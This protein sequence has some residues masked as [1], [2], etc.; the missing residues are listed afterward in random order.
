MAFEDAETLA[1]A[2]SSYYK[3]TKS[4]EQVVLAQV[5]SKWEQH[6]LPRVDKILEFTTQ[7]GT[8]RKES[9]YYQQ[10]VKEW[11]MWAFFKVRG[12]QG[13]GGWMYYYNAE[14]V[15]SDLA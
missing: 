9:P 4:G 5:I 14:S 7:N 11:L 15:L 2:L 13:G 3:K 12:P 1:Y 8:M 10:V 6:R